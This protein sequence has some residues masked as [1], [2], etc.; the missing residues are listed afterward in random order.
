MKAL[1]RYGEIATIKRQFLI[2]IRVQVG[3]LVVSYRVMGMAHSPLAMWR[4][5]AKNNSPS[6]T[7][8]IKEISQIADNQRGSY[9]LSAVQPCVGVGIDARASNLKQ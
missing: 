2:Q 5:A 1:R 9:A 3:F 4:R 8:D 7:A 6:V